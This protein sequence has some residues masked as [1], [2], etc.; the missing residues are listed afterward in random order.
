ML[1]L[2]HYILLAL[3]PL[4]PRYVSRLTLARVA[5]SAVGNLFQ[6]IVH[7]G[8]P[9]RQDE[10][11]NLRLLL[12]GIS[13][14]CAYFTVLRIVIIRLLAIL[15]DGT[16]GGDKTAMRTVD[17]HERGNKCLNLLK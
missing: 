1:A 15:Y 7:V 9:V 17:P 6:T 2:S 4:F 16:F 13:N 11:N 10:E 3:N 14:L 12:I 8:I 5:K